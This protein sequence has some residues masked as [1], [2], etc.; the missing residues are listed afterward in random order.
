MGELI[1][2]LFGGFLG[3]V[4]LYICFDVVPTGHFVR[5]FSKEPY[6]ESGSILDREYKRCWKV[7]EVEPTP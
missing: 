5:T 2:A 6:C 3:G 1:C 4:M 7:V